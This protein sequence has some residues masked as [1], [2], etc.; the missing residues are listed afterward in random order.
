MLIFN[1]EG[2]YFLAYILIPSTKKISYR[3]VSNCSTEPKKE[4]FFY[5]ESM[6]NIQQAKL[7][8]DV[9]VGPVSA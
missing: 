9:N 6:N 8:K 3:P 7:N 5:V 4:M 2:N 1:L